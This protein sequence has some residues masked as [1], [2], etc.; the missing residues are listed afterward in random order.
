[1]GVCTSRGDGVEEPGNVH[2]PQGSSV[3]V[4]GY[5]V[6]MRPTLYKAAKLGFHTELLYFK[7]SSILKINLYLPDKIGLQ[8]GFGSCSSL[9]QYHLSKKDHI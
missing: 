2:P 8:T 7:M 1:M 3:S 6:G 5:H 9:Q 4:R